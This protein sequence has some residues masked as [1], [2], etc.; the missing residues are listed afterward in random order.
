MTDAPG[1]LCP[2]ASSTV[3]AVAALFAA[4]APGRAMVGPSAEDAALA[5][6]AIMILSR[7]GA[8]AGYCSAVVVA[9]AA[10]LTA[11]HCVPP[12]GALKLFFRDAAGA[13]VL[14]DVADVE[15]HPGYRADAIRKRE[16]SIDLALVRLP[17]PLPGRFE[18]ATL[19]G[20]APPPA[21]GARFRVA[22]YGLSREDAP[23]TSGTLRV[24]T[25]AARAPASAVLLWADDPTGRG[26]G[27]C[28][29]DSGGVR[30]RRRRGG[31]GHG[32]VRR[33]RPNPM[34]HA[35]ASRLASAADGLDRRRPRALG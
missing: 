32:M 10:V 25:L 1:G 8:V 35:D 19:G 2:R 22:G 28:T 13:P 24:A 29:G 15:R 18:P 26:A 34:W 9:R 33:N 30:G 6:H 27:A 17:A 20:S 5:S 4:T 31:G 3:I 21:L 11:A 16:R 7:S 23:A 12:G 14:L